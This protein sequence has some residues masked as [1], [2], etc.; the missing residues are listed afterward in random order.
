MKMVGCGMEIRRYEKFDHDVLPF[1][2]TEYMWGLKNPQHFCFPDLHIHW[3]WPLSELI[4][5]SF[6]SLTSRYLLYDYLLSSTDKALLIFILWK[7]KHLQEHSIYSI[8]APHCTFLFNLSK[9]KKEN[10]ASSGFQRKMLE[11]LTNFPTVFTTLFHVTW[12]SRDNEIIHNT[13]PI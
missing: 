2:E 7:L 10:N 3:D 4:M 1:P 6:D 13:W 5:F 12:N 8:E 9:N 11:A